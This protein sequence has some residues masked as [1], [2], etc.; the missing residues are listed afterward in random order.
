MSKTVYI[1][2]AGFSKDLGCPQQNQLISEILGLPIDDVDFDLRTVFQEYRDVFQTFLSDTLYISPDKFSSISLED[3]YT[4]IDRC[5]IDNTSFR[6]INKQELVQLRQKINLLISVLIHQK[7]KTTSND[8]YADKF[9][10]YLVNLK[11]GNNNVRDPFAVISLNWDILMDNALYGNIVHQEGV[12]DYCCYIS[13]YSSNDIYLTGQKALG[14][15]LFNVKLLKIHGSLNWLQCSMCQRLFV[16]FGEKIAINEFKPILKPVCRFCSENFQQEIKREI[17]LNSLLVMPT[18]LKDFN[19]VQLKLIWHN[20]GIELSEA[21]KIVFMGY[22]FPAADFEL[23]QLLARFVRH[24][25]SIEVV[26]KG[27]K[28]SKN[29]D[30]PE[31]RYR[32]FFGKRDVRVTYQGVEKYIDALQI[33]QEIN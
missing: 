33:A 18:F 20:T 27:T 2:G 13:S 19:N 9:A 11:T 12:V 32:S 4:P 25:A 5:I 29:T 10:K 21:D 30:S 14:A 23:R 16:A 1:L 8:N 15:G 28:P 31:N 6:G 26:L 24:D 7:L 3:I 17:F 22:S